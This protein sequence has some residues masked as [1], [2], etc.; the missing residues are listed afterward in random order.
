M[1]EKAQGCYKDTII[2]C[3]AFI[4]IKPLPSSQRLWEDSYANNE[5]LPL[6][7]YA[8]W[9]NILDPNISFIQSKIIEV[10]SSW[11]KTVRNLQDKKGRYLFMMLWDTFFV[12]YIAKW[13]R[14]SRLPDCTNVGR[15]LA[16]MPKISYSDWNR[17]VYI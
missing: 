4:H 8:G 15:Y 11:A 12:L 13:P 1:L 10:E 7:S 17:I 5:G 14:L 6:I 9:W 16:S 2:L 3:L